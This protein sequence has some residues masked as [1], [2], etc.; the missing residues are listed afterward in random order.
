MKN[1]LVIL[2]FGVLQVG[3]GQN[4]HELEKAINLIEKE[5]F[6]KSLKILNQVIS[7]DSSLL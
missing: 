2:F 3:L 5:D 7:A 4:S 6:I 1:L